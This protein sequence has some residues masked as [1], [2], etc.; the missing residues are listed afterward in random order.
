[1]SN[2]VVRKC[3]KKLFGDN[4]EVKVRFSYVEDAEYGPEDYLNFAEKAN[5]IG[6]KIDLK[7]FKKLSGLS[8]I[9]EDDVWEPPKKE[10]SPE[11][12]SEEK[13]QLKETEEFKLNA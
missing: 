6:M 9:V 1:M 8:F 12:T 7:E 4:A 10:P 13:E 3:V 11:W 5:A 2:S